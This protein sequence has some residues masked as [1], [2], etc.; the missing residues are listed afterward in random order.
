MKQSIMERIRLR[1]R[2]AGQG[3]TEYII[4]VA[5]VGV[6]AIATYTYFGDAVRYQVSAAAKA[7]GGQDSVDV[8]GKAQAAAADAE[9]NSKRH[10]STFGED[11]N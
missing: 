1:A 8:T 3:M 6:A 11:R 5:V 9:T 4:I 2:Q 10:L 7:L